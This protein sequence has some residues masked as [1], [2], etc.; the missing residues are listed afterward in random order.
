MSATAPN[1]ETQSHPEQPAVAKG[2]VGDIRPIPRITIQ[3]FCESDAVRQTLELSSGD[4][5]MARAH[6][7]V[8]MGGI[9]GA[10]EFYGSSPTPNLVIV[11]SSL[12]G[13]SL[14]A[15]LGRLASVCD[16]DTKVV[17]IGSF[18][19]ILM[20]RELIGHGVSEYLVAPVSMADIMA[21]ISGI[22][23]ESEKRCP[24]PHD[25][26]YRCKGWMRIIHNLS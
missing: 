13:D 12:M 18:N 3:A 24:G 7:A 14:V 15:E 11:E 19:D 26:V 6:V 17:V 4:R 1:S 25:C 10:V 9:P 5:R 20:Y 2:D 22:F 16:G 23:S 21:T 8:Q